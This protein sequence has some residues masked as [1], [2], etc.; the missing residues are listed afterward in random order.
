M[1]ERLAKALAILRENL[2]KPNEGTNEL[3]T[4]TYTKLRDGAWGIR[5]T[6]PI[7]A[8]QQVQVT[9]RDGRVK[10]ETVGTIV[11]QSNGATVATTARGDSQAAP[12]AVT[13]VAP[14]APV[15]APVAP[16]ARVTSAGLDQ[17]IADLETALAG[18]KA[19]R[20]A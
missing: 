3:M 10:T 5:A 4:T 9:T 18:L 20:A 11:W 19:L 7:V 15:A 6:G 17:I 1:D 16:V 13:P 14:I 8:G 12:V 2:G